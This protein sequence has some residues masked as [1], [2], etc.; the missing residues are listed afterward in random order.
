LQTSIRPPRDG[1]PKWEIR[2]H[3]PRQMIGLKGHYTRQGLSVPVRSVSPFS[4]PSSNLAQP[5]HSGAIRLATGQHGPDYPSVLVGDRDRRAVVTATPYQP[6]PLVA[7]WNFPRARL[8]GRAVRPQR[9]PR[10]DEVLAAPRMW[11]ASG[12][13]VLTRSS[14][15]SQRRFAAKYVASAGFFH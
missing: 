3:S 7:C 2:S 14:L 6:G 10:L 13:Y 12:F 8:R 15:L 4:D 1:A 9:S 5:S 11:G